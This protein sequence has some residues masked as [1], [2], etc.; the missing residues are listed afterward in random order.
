MS[1]KK[2]L[3]DSISEHTKKINKLISEFKFMAANCENED[4]QYLCNKAWQSLQDLNDC[5]REVMK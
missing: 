2:E 1:N 5:L 3:S 4:T